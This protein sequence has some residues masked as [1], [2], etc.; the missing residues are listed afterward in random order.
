[1]SDPFLE[2][3]NRFKY[4]FENEHFLAFVQAV[5]YHLLY[6]TNCIGKTVIT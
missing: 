1:M 5:T 3:S 4:S 2:G 6:F